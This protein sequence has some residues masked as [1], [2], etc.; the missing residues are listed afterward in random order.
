MRRNRT[1]QRAKEPAAPSWRPASEPNIRQPSVPPEF[2]SYTTPKIESPTK[3]VPTKP[4]RDE[5]K[6]AP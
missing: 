3:P 2:R 1:E 5:E 4:E 6:V